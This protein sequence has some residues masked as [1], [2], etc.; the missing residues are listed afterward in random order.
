M[1]SL[2]IQSPGM[3]IANLRMLFGKI[4]EAGLT[5]RPSK[6]MISFRRVD[7]LGHVVENGTVT[8]ETYKLEKIQ[9]VE[10]PTTKKQV[11]AFIGP[12][13]YYRKFTPNFAEIAVPLTNLTKK[14]QPV[15]VS[16]GLG[17]QHAFSAI[18]NLLNRPP[19]LC[20]PDFNC[21]FIVQAD[22]SETVVRTAL[23]QD[24][25]DGR[26]PVAYTSKKLL[27]RERNYLVIERECLAIVYVVKKVQKYLHCKEFI[28]HT[29]YQPLH[30][31]QRSRMESGR[32]MRLALFLH[33]FKFRIEAIKES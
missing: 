28:L 21:L 6:C 32:M 5:I 23:M 22:A 24:Y 26:F 19:I 17:Q 33:N 9:D 18:Q 12:V 20:L 3:P 30:Y 14:G 25:D 13:G 8:M 10:P 1:M 29:G 7:F 27:P 11:R 2:N 4:R 31:I 15:K 16:W